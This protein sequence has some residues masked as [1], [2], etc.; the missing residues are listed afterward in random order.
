M[1][2]LVWS[3]ERNDKTLT[4]TP[5]GIFLMTASDWEFCVM[6]ANIE[7]ESVY[8]VIIH[9]DADCG[10]GGPQGGGILSYISHI[11]MC[12]LKG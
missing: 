1:L 4:P 5:T 8:E 9:L 12:G 6:I 3:R 10:G 7:C 2:H 11:G